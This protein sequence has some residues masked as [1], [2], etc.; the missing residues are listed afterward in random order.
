MMGRLEGA[1]GEFELASEWGPPVAENR[2]RETLINYC[3]R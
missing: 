2:S 3:A 1:V